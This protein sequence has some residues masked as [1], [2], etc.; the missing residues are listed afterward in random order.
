MT[1]WKEHDDEAEKNTKFMFKSHETHILERISFNTISK[2][3]Y[4]VHRR[5]YRHASYIA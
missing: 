5:V 1:Q 2:N 3:M 4:I